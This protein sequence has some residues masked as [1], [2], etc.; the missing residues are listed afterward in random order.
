MVSILESFSSLRYGNYIKSHLIV[1]T[2]K[3][4]NQL[5]I[6]DISDQHL[7]VYEPTS[8][9]NFTPIPLQHHLLQLL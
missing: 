6:L 9:I 4:L 3:L 2:H 7:T 5:T 8:F 1:I